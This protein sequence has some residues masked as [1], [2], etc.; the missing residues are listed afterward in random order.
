[1]VCGVSLSAEVER[2]KRAAG[3]EALDDHEFLRAVVAA[4]KECE[5]R[6]LEDETYDYD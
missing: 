2:A 5:L 1:M 4:W 6:D 3:L